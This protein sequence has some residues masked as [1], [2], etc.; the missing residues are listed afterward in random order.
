MR[1]N[2]FKEEQQMRALLL[3]TPSVLVLCLVSI[4]A[5]AFAAETKD[6]PQLAVYEW[7]EQGHTNQVVVYQSEAGEDLKE[8]RVSLNIGLKPSP[9]GGCVV[10]DP[11]GG[12]YQFVF[13]P[14]YRTPFV[15]VNVSIDPQFL[16]SYPSPSSNPPFEEIIRLG[17]NFDPHPWECA[18]QVINH[19]HK[20]EE[21]RDLWSQGSEREKMASEVLKRL[22]DFE[23][24]DKAFFVEF[25]YYAPRT[26][27]SGQAQ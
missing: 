1:Y 12:F 13:R 18:L 17:L 6:N 4:S 7:Q 15:K 26:L 23:W 16:A 21:I 27:V 8:Y 25:S 9:E 11:N 2:I 24:E 14:G 10:G 19:R 5:L 3:Y 22:L 20:L